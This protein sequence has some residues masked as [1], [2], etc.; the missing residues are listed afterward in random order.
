MSSLSSLLGG[1]VRIVTAMVG[2][3]FVQTNVNTLAQA[4]GATTAASGT[5]SAGVLKTA[6]SVSGKGCLNWGAIYSTSA[7][8][9]TLRIQITI[10]GTVVR[11]FTSSSVNVANTGYVF[12]GTGFYSASASSAA[13]QPLFFKTSLLVEFADSTAETNGL[14]FASNHEVHA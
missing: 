6:L 11:N 3:P 1:G 4:A 2:T 8:S 9:K 12:C 14:T 13:F 5:V 7:T 10:D